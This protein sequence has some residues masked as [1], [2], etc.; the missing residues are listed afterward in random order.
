MGWGTTFTADLYYNKLFSNEEEVKAEI[1]MLEVNAEQVMSK[2][3]M[4]A[5]ANPDSIFAPQE[6]E[7]LIRVLNEEV[8]ELLEEY[9]SIH[10]DL[11]I[12]YTLLEN[13]ETMKQDV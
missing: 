6:G 3:K 1:G 9:A 4:L 13:I 11:C 10:R 8:N 7:S 12:L 2:I 5:A